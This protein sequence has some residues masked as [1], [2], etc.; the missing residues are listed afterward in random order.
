MA[1]TAT[2]NAACVPVTIGTQP[3][4]NNMCAVTGN[5]LFT[6]TPNGSAPFAFQ[7]QYY[8]GA[9]WETINTGTP[10]GASYTNATTAALTV[11]GITTPGSYQYRCYITNCSGANNAT[12]SAA[13]L[14]VNPGTPSQPGAI[15]G[16][17]TQCPGINESDIQHKC[18]CQCNHLY[19][20]S[21]VRMVHHRRRRNYLNKCNNRISRTEWHYKCFSRKYLWH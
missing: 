4:A 6:V 19:M 21:P 3:S 10:T 20:D 13:T 14:T 1:G 16:T 15:S 5:A 9:T 18:S 12:T 7:W 11:S 17:A 8:N 2:V